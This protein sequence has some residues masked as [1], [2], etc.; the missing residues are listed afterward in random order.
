MTPFFKKKSKC[1]EKLGEYTHQGICL[2][3]LPLGSGILGVFFGFLLFDGQDFLT[4]LPK[5]IPSKMR[6]KT[7]ALRHFLMF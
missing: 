1:L 5:T 4:A 6:G 7:K 3:W 2:L